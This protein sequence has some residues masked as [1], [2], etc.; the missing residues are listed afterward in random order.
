MRCW[1]CRLMITS[2]SGT[3]SSSYQTWSTC[4]L[5]R[6]AFPSRNG[7][8]TLCHRLHPCARYSR[9]RSI[10]VAWTK[11]V[12][13]Y[14][15]KCHHGNALLSTNV[16]LDRQC[17]WTDVSSRPNFYMVYVCLETVLF[18]NRSCSLSLSNWA[19]GQPELTIRTE[20]ECIYCNPV[21][22][23]VLS[24]PKFTSAA[25]QTNSRSLRDD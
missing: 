20:Q 13:S 10:V 8:K 6:M 25:E 2:R 17:S 12:L 4:S 5:L 18:S 24:Q 15:L 16:L 3:W 22:T 1:H 9:R 19:A 11:S 21:K 7:L 14:A 23:T